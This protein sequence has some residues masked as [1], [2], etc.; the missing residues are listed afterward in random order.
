MLF[1]Q[2]SYVTI[3][4]YEKNLAQ[5]VYQMWEIPVAVSHKIER[6]ANLWENDLGAVVTLIPIRYKAALWTA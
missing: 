3:S 5:S 6:C 1:F 2:V 4:H